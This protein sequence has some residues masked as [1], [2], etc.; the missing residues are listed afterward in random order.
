M[1]N[2]LPVNK[3][4]NLFDVMTSF[5][6][7]FP[8]GCFLKMAPSKEQCYEVIRLYY[9]S[10]SLKTVVKTMRKTHPEIG[11]FN[12][13]QVQRIVKRF[14]ESDSVEDRRH[15]N[16]GRPRSARTVENLEQLKTAINETPQRSVRRVLGDVTNSTSVTSV[17]RMLKFDLQL[18]PYKVSI[19]QHLKEADITSRLSFANWITSHTDVAEKLWFSD[20]AHFYLNAQVNKQNC[21][22][23]SSL[24][25]NLTFTLKNHYME[26]GLRFWLH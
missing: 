1:N 13:K 25:R 20:E 3:N 24:L 16:T 15:N 4:G 12:A 7:S 10:K 14:E 11:T 22:Y 18:T 21:R 19:M 8:V 5:M 2:I 26:K 9:Q 17:Y 23:W 6:T